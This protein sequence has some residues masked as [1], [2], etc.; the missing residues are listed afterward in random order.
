VQKWF[1]YIHKVASKHEHVSE[2]F[3]Y[4]LN[5]SSKLTENFSTFISAQIIDIEKEIDY[6]QI[7]ELISFAHDELE[8]IE[9]Y[10]GK[11]IGDIKLNALNARHCTTS[12][13]CMVGFCNLKVCLITKPFP[14][15]SFI[16]A[17]KGWE[18]VAAAK[19]EADY[20]KKEMA[21]TLFFSDPLNHRK[22]AP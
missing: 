17:E 2:N 4:T 14:M 7:E 20:V 18:R 15:H 22:A 21:D 13:I 1:S 6:G 10:Y 12:L 5:T 3:H 9:Y 11:F 8:L 19:L 16:A